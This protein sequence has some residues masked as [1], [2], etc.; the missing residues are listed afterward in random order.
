MIA[1]RRLYP[2][3]L[4]LAL[5]APFSACA[6]ADATNDGPATA[7]P[8]GK[9][10]DYYSDVAQEF[11]VSGSIRVTLDEACAADEACRKEKIERRLTGVSLYLTA[12]LTNKLENFFKNMTYGGFS[13]MARNH[14]VEA[15]D[16]TET[17]PG[18]LD[19]KFSVSV[20]GPKELINK[21]P[22]LPD[23]EPGIFAFEL[24]MPAGYES[25]PEWVDRGAI[26]NF[27]PATYSG[28]IE[29]VV[30]TIKPEKTPTDAYPEF[31]GMMSDGMFD[32]TLF[33]GHDYNESRSDLQEAREAFAT[34]TTPPLDMTAPVATFENLGPE[35]GPFTRTISVAGREVKVEVRIFH[36][37]MFKADRKLAHD[38]SL[39]ELASRDVFVYGGHAGPFYGF[40]LSADASQWDVKPIEF[41][42]YPMTSKPQLVLAQGCQTYSQYADILYANPAKGEDSGNPDV[43]TTVNFSYGVGTMGFVKNILALDS[44]GEHR[45]ATFHKIL[46]DLN[47]EYWNRAKEVFY[48]VHGIEA[49][50]RIHPYADPARL[51][52]A[53]AVAADCGTAGAYE[54]VTM[55]PGEGAICGLSALEKATCPETTTLYGLTR[56]GRTIYGYACLPTAG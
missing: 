56:D 9:A 46:S 11:E 50:P 1:V 25:S 42:T 31:A 18:N 2:S 15:E 21:L 35:S 44:A 49:N 19:V 20:G 10:D 30:C 39:S 52:A 38:L 48:G 16:V 14:T 45:P 40:Y 33:F 17:S 13:A 23:G 36:S 24:A 7:V 51:G 22:L 12:Y 8:M 3:L 6:P 43:I 26:R 5:L 54:C 27:D 55:K 4:A 34:L 32:L 53:C 29:K 37:D 47:A 28:E 41:S